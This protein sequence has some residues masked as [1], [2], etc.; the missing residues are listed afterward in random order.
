MH[1]RVIL[2]SVTGMI[3]VFMALVSLVLVAYSL[4]QANRAIQANTAEAAASCTR[5][6][7]LRSD[8]LRLIHNQ[9]VITPRTPPDEAASIQRFLDEAD[10]DL[11]PV[12]CP[13]AHSR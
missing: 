2:W 13:A 3:A 8:V 6:N 9:L 10:H 11:A 7:V 12:H 4:G 1:N 5:S